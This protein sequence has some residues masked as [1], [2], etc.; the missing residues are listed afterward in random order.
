MNIKY[1]HLSL[2][3]IM[4]LA[5]CSLIFLQQGIFAGDSPPGA[6]EETDSFKLYDDM[7]CGITAFR[8]GVLSTIDIKP[9]APT[10]DISVYL[11]S[12]PIHFISS[13]EYT[14][15]TREIGKFK[16][17]KH[18]EFSSAFNPNIQSFVRIYETEMLFIEGGNEYWIPV[19]E[20][21]IRD[22]ARYDV[23]PGDKIS[24]RII[25]L[26]VEFFKDGTK[27]YGFFMQAFA[28]QKK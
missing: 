28:K 14:G 15:E 21:T 3:T 8:E 4:V 27:E 2:K 19:Q 18:L 7:H 12:K 11:N 22:L 13:A 16:K 25:Y 5:V 17:E 9:F 23:K 10:Q 6:G 20:K 26:W 24:L 1:L